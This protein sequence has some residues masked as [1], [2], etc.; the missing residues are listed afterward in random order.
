M[1]QRAGRDSGHLPLGLG[2]LYEDRDI[3]VVDKPPGLLTISTDTEKSRTAYHVLREDVR[4]GQAKS[5]QRLFIVP[6][7][8]RETSGVLLFAKTPAAKIRLQGQWEE[9]RKQYFAVVH[10]T[11]EQAAGTISTYLAENRAHV[12]YTTTNPREGRRAKTAYRVVEQAPHAALL[13]IDLLT[14]R[15]HQ[16][17]VHMADLG[18][19]VVGDT[20][21]GPEERGRAR[22]ALH[23]RSISFA[24]P[25]DGTP[26]TIDTP[27][28]PSFKAL[29]HAPASRQPPAR[30][31]APRRRR[32]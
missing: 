25:F 23:A 1:R 21:Y 30:R 13:E 14:G 22:L 20:K 12:V 7:L 4:Q 8:D 28:P 17:R 26:M 15:K 19:P 27:L 24:H 29:L 2:I 11:M 5:R 3:I 10:G 31:P 6:R 16:I 32:T 9:T 18:H